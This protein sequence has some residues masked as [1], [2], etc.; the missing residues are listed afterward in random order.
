MKMLYAFLC[1]F[2][3]KNTKIGVSLRIYERL[4]TY[5]NSYSAEGHIAGFDI[6]WVGKDRHIDRLEKELKNVFNKNIADDTRG[7]SEW[8]SGYTPDDVA[9]KVEELIDGFGLRHHIKRIGAEDLPV[10]VY[11]LDEVLEKYQD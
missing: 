9:A 2:G 10:T 3:T 11:N 4:G 6:A 8:V 7:F 5:Q 1:P